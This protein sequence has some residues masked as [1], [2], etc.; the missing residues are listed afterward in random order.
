MSRK[1]S[2]NILKVISAI[3]VTKITILI[4]KDISVSSSHTKYHKYQCC[5]AVKEKITK[6]RVNNIQ[7][8][9]HRYLVISNPLFTVNP[10]S[11]RRRARL[12]V[13]VAWILSFLLASPQA[14][15]FRWAEESFL[16]KCWHSSFVLCPFKGKIC[17]NLKEFNNFDLKFS[18]LLLF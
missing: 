6:A 1:T 15:M 9:Q 5:F 11:M 16:L 10:S 8:T 7:Y 17:E 13:A 12:M 4:K 2:W 3:K 14:F 18:A